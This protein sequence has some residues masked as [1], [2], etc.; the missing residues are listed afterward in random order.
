[1]STAKI[2]ERFAAA[3]DALFEG[4]SEKASALMAEAAVA[5]AP[6]VDIDVL[7]QTLE[8]RA[9]TTS[10]ARQ[11]LAEHPGIAKDPDMVL[12]ADRAADLKV[13]GGMRADAAITEACS[14]IAQKY[15]LDAAIKEPARRARSA[16]QATQDAE[17]DPQAAVAREGLAFLQRSRHGNS[18]I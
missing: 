15:N 6:Q 9:A 16:S 2:Q 13:R 4:D 11:M 17:D 8:R 7:A 1:M 10:A 5:A 14:E 3:A 12:L 18:S